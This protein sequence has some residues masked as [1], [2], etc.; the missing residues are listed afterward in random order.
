MKLTVD[1]QEAYAYT[2]GKAFDPAKPDAYVNSLAA[3][4]GAG[5][6]WASRGPPPPPMGPD[7]D[8]PMRGGPDADHT[9]R[10]R[11]GVV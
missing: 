11:M 10:R 7:L 2:G 6:M 4:G 9:A 1:G 3:L 8:V 5:P